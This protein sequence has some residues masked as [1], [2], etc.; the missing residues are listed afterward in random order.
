[1]SH[2]NDKLSFTSKSVEMHIHNASLHSLKR[3]K[4]VEILRDPAIV[5]F[6]RKHVVGNLFEKNNSKER[7]TYKIL[8]KIQK[9]EKEIFDIWK[10]SVH[11][12][13]VYF[14]GIF[15]MISKY[16]LPFNIYRI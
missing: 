16:R 4:Y 11:V 15:V 13:P 9:N 3:K 7:R 6:C 14:N 1:M 5:H 12:L 10:L 2:E 8:I